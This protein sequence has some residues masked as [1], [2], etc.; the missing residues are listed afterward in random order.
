MKNNKT[1]LLLMLASSLIRRRTRMAVALIGIAIGATV[2]LGMIIL[3][4]EV[5]KQMS[6]EFRSYGANMAFMPAGE[7]GS[8]LLEDIEQAA[9]LLPEDQLIGVT[10]FRYLPVRSHMLPYTAVG[11]VFEQV[12]KTSPYW[13]VEGEWPSAEN[14]VL[15]GFDIA[16]IT[17]LKPGA[18]IPLDGR[19]EAQARFERNVKITGVLKTG[20]VEDGFIFMDL[21]NL[22]DMMNNPDKQVRADFAEVSLASSQ[23]GLNSI[24][25]IVSGQVPGIEPRLVKRVAQSE[26]AVLGKLSTLVY[27]VTSVVLLLTMICVAT[28]MMTVVMERRRE[29][30]LKKAIGAENRSIAFE[31]LA[32]GVLLGAAGGIVGVV[33]GLAFAQL[34]SASVFGRSISIELYLIPVTIAVSVAVTVLACLIPVRRATDVE[35]ALVLRG[36]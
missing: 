12:K 2:L 13:Q 1:F 34:I 9:R 25:P 23:D 4:Y 36:E 16:E 24:I 8:I 20:G 17:K 26:A 5:P 14:E 22:H 18:V 19:N 35:P 7:A 27:M 30:G 3:C 32:E 31:F 29:V 6:Q 33:L 10:P 21:H 11:T 28:T 15:I